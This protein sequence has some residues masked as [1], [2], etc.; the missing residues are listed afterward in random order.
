MSL[1]FRIIPVY[2]IMIITQL[3]SK[4]YPHNYR[5]VIYGS[6]AEI[7]R[8][9]FV[10]ALM[11]NALDRNDGRFSNETQFCGGSIISHT[12]VITSGF[13]ITKYIIKHEIDPLDWFVRCGT[14]DWQAVPPQKYQKDYNVNDYYVHIKSRY[15]IVENFQKI[16]LLPPEL[17]GFDYDVGLI[18]VQGKFVFN[19]GVSPIILAG[20]K[21]RYVEY[22]RCGVLG[23]GRTATKKDNSHLHVAKLKIENYTV[24]KEMYRNIGYTITERMFCAG[25]LEGGPNSCEGDTGGPLFQ[26]FREALVL[27]GIASFS[28]GCGQENFPAFYTKVSKFQDSILSYANE[29]RFYD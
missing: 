7:T 4:K 10:V 13:C 14:T 17:P 16:H 8:Y 21:F 22:T 20:I 28:K 29:T 11:I 18:K 26:K 24:C 3:N 15:N 2:L 9:P 19:K 27:I 25:F 6:P 1:A 12:W 5:K 23:Y